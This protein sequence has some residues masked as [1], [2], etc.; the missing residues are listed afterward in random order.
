MMHCRCVASQETYVRALAEDADASRM[1]MPARAM[2]ASSHDVCNVPNLTFDSV[3]G[4][5]WEEEYAKLPDWLRQHA[6]RDIWFATE[7][8][9]LRFVLPP[10]VRLY[11]RNVVLEVV[12]L[13]ALHRNVYEA[14]STDKILGHPNEGESLGKRASLIHLKQGWSRNPKRQRIQRAMPKSQT[15]VSVYDAWLELVLQTQEQLWTTMTSTLSTTLSRPRYKRS[16]KW[17]TRA[18][19]RIY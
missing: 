8:D 10:K 6:S 1:Q 2:A 3:V 7:V 17:K 4:V 13:H 16:G 15:L 14:K 19:Y 12:S 9:A 11:L 18:P 5:C